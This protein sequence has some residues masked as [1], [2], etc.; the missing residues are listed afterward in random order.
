MLALHVR[1]LG[2]SSQHFRILKDKVSTFYSAN[3]KQSWL[4]VYKEVVQLGM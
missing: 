4:I 1:G 3:K 2:F